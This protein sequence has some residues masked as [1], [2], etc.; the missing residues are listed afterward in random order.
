MALADAAGSAVRG[1]RDEV[2]MIGVR[3]FGATYR[4]RMKEAADLAAEF[5]GARW[6]RLSRP[7][8][9]G[10]GICSLRSAK[11]WSG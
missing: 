4:G 10:N 2:D 11:R 7:Q 3:M 6:M 1:P 9:A 5:P 8:S